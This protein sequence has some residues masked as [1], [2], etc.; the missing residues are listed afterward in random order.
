MEARMRKLVSIVAAGLVMAIAVAHG[1]EKP[2][3]AP[4]R[5][6]EGTLIANE[7]A[8]QAAVAQKDTSA[9]V[10][11]V[12]PDGAWTTTQGFVEMKVLAES[13]LGLDV[14]T[15]EIVNPHVI[16]LTDDSALVIYVWSGT[17][18]GQS[19]PVM[20][21]ASTAWAKRDGRWR[22]AHHQRTE[23]VKE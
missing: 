6:F 7:R 19:A 9:F 2:T 20:T 11:L 15:F 17:R 13:L 12:L 16:R 3:G 21:L 5:S 22:A 10:S 4:N 18:H 8:L 1:Q 23:L 14:T